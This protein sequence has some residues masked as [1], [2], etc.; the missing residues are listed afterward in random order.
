MSIRC[1]MAKSSRS[2]SGPV[3]VKYTTGL[4]ILTCFFTVTGC[5]LLP[6]QQAPLAPPLVKPAPIH[7]QT[8]AVHRGNIINAITGTATVI[9]TRQVALSYRTP[10]GHIQEIDVQAGVHVHRGQVL[11]RLDTSDVQ[12]QLQ[13]TQ[14][15]QEKDSLKVDE[16]KA[17]HAN[18]YQIQMA[19]LDVKGDAIK[20]AYL[21]HQI[22]DSELV[23]PLDGVVTDITNHRIGDSVN[24]NEPLVTIAD[25]NQLALSYSTLDSQTGSEIKPGMAVNIQFS[26]QS[27]AG[28]VTRVHSDDTTYATDVWIVPDTVPS[29]MKM[30]NSV[31]FQIVT[32]KKL[33]VLMVPKDAVHQ[34]FG[35]TYV[36]ILNGSLVQ[37]VAVQIGAENA[38]DAEVVSGLTNGEQV[39]LQ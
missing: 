37:Q 31:D 10:T 28:K 7:Y 34:D 36:R 6:Q 35:S 15:Q 8:V 9:S 3:S 1:K 17:G 29:S 25:T 39:I 11:M 21:Q 22:S 23:A 24:P 13:E 38:T 5:S 2:K 26:N 18:S 12:F 16:L 30:G 4:A 14:L 33:N 32:Q 20:I 27:M 19:Q